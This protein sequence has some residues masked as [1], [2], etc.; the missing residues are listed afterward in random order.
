M[1]HRIES[2]DMACEKDAMH[3]IV[4][5]I[6]WTREHFFAS[7]AKEVEELT[8]SFFSQMNFD[9][10]GKRMLDIG[11]GIGR[12]TRA[13]SDMFSEAYGVDFSPQMIR[14]AKE[15]NKD[16]PNLFFMTNN[17][18]DLA[19]FEDNFFAFCF[20]YLVFQHIPDVKIIESY[21]C[22]MCR[23]LKPR[24]LFKFQVDGRKWGPMRMP[25]IHRSLFNFLLKIGFVDKF[26]KFHFR[27]DSY[28][29]QIYPGVWLSSRKLERMLQQTSLEVVEITGKDS[30]MLWCSG[31]KRSEAI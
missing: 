18:I 3:Y 11:C 12:M 27:G 30:R 10:T 14:R 15:L 24:G 8:T 16:K 2:W 28:K 26:A 17:G 7:G 1:K 31:N 25:I 23:V 19:N 29:A 5:G 4:D 21:I 20:T 9:P 22:E 6:T 13:F